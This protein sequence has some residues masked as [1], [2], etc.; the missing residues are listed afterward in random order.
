MTALQSAQQFIK[1][2]K[3]QADP[4]VRDGP[5][6]ID[7]AEQAWQ[8]ASF[9]LPNKAE[10]IAD[11]I[12]SKFFKERGN[13]LATNVLV[14][15][16]Y[17][18][19]LSKLLS[20]PSPN[21]QPSSPQ[22][23]L[24]LKSSLSRISIAP[25][26]NAFLNLWSQLD[27]SQSTQLMAQASYCISILYPLGTQKLTTEAF[28][29]SWGSF[30]K[31]AENF[32]DNASSIKIGLI[33]TRAYKNSL[34]N[35][36]SRKKVNNLF[37]QNESYFQAWLQRLQDKS[38][39][40]QYE[41]LRQAILTCGMDTL[42][43]L[44]T[45][46]QMTDSLE[47]SPICLALYKAFQNDRN[48][49]L[50][51]LPPLFDHYIA[52]L[53]K[54][55]GAII[56]ASSSSRVP[57]QTELNSASS[58]FFL[59]LRNLVDAQKRD[60]SAW[61]AVSQMVDVIGRENIYHPQ[62]GL[63]S[64]KHEVDIALNSLSEPGEDQESNPTPA[65]ARCLSAVIR[66][67]YDLVL[68]SMGALLSSFL[69]IP[70]PHPDH[71]TLL[72]LLLEYHTKTRTVDHYIETLIS[73]LS[74]DPSASPPSAQGRYAIS[75]SSPIL[76]PEHLGQLSKA[77]RQF[78]TSGQCNT[79]V[80]HFC[81]AL[82]ALH[83]HYKTA[84]RRSEADQGNGSRKSR[85][86]D[87]SAGH[88]EDLSN[89]ALTF[90]LMAKLGQTV[91]SSI[92]MTSLPQDQAEQ[93][94]SSLA[95]FQA[96][97]AQ[98][99]ISK[100]LKL[101]LQSEIASRGD[102]KTSLKRKR[103]GESPT[104]EA[105]IMLIGLLRLHY[106]LRMARSLA[107]PST[108]SPKLTK[109]LLELL[110]H[111][112]DE[113]LP[114]LYLEIFRTLFDLGLAMDATE[115]SQ[116]IDFALA[117]VDKT[118]MP[119]LDTIWS[120]FAHELTFGP[121]GRAQAGL[122]V[123]HMI[124]E[125]WLPVIEL[126]AS[127]QQLEAL[128]KVITRIPLGTGAVQD[129]QQLLSAGRL[130][131]RTLRS[132]QFWE[133]HNFRVALLSRLLN[134]TSN[135]EGEP[136]KSSH[137]NKALKLVVTYRLL[138]FFPAEYLRKSCRADLVETAIQADR[139][140]SQRVEGATET[141]ASLSTLRTFLKR[142]FGFLGSI[143]EQSTS[144]LAEFILHLLD[145]WTTA[146]Q[147]E[148]SQT[149]LD[150]FELY[151]TELLKKTVRADSGE[152]S[153]VL[154]T[155]RQYPIFDTLGSI[156][157]RSLVCL[158]DL[159]NKEFR[160]ASLSP[161]LQKLLNELHLHLLTDLHDKLRA[162]INASRSEHLSV[163]PDLLT[164]WHSLLVL[165]RWLG[166]EDLQ[167]S[168][169]PQ[170]VQKFTTTFAERLQG[171]SNDWTDRTVTMVV[172]ILLQELQYCDDMV[173]NDQLGLVVAAYVSQWKH[174][175]LA[176]KASLDQVVSN[177]CRQLSP[178]GFEYVLSLLDGAL[179]S[180]FDD[181]IDSSELVH[182]GSILL[183]D[184]PPNTLKIIQA[185]FTRCMAIYTD[186][187]KYTAI[188]T[189][190]RLQTL[191]FVAQHC[192]ERPAALRLLDIG[193]IWLLL[194]KCLSPS[195]RHEKVTSSSTF[196]QIISIASAIIRLRRDLTI[197]ML[198]HLGMILRQVTLCMR[199]CRPQLGSKQT[200]MVMSTQ[201]RWISANQPLGAEEAKALSR[202]L[203]TLTTKTIVR[204]HTASAETQKAESLA[205]PFSKH[206]AYVLKAYIEA[207]NDP[208]CVLA[209]D[210]RKELY[211]GLYALCSMIGE[212]SRD[213]LMVSGLDT[214]GKATMKAL[215]KEYEKQ[216]Y[217]GQ[218]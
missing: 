202:L 183:R 116:T 204:V 61:D 155:Y 26:I 128:A 167:R 114:E 172:A 96:G 20:S 126:T 162:A 82:K 40:A 10:V 191:E 1:A 47:E 7:L 136:E 187:E 107:L 161:D 198:P 36:S 13:V 194:S 153:K 97:F 56:S 175:S 205:A 209:L 42:F 110:S 50:K 163:V 24:W 186:N 17:W 98:N 121:E 44:D 143:E 133:F 27:A 210:V 192:A 18:G 45:I 148:L 87:S 199:Q 181:S 51:A 89:L 147:T 145:D 4:P 84:L 156:K 218:G 201:P 31:N 6:K 80:D 206:A 200:D 54:H 212:H 125:R 213:A 75:H 57:D 122:A 118:L 184:H 123:L 22:T 5:L 168:F 176:G 124:L 60:V 157:A 19:L 46:R 178:S 79:A 76:H 185:F 189:G 3:A 102:D 113:L 73:N 78:L 131:F 135:L 43:N 149:T 115:A 208:L 117:F 127:G 216:R 196:H 92:P 21:V 152:A 94:K 100:I 120:G 69:T 195:P 150:L 12:L 190:V 90:S 53:R 180:D 104:W 146:T 38:P 77:T 55:R 35:S 151:F 142:T 66:V 88:Q 166:L 160:F 188:S 130:L 34:S 177:A 217:S 68:P 158:I 164:Y 11:W 85:K 173:Q 39:A 197:P 14:N 132:A 37:V 48:V 165:G 41:Y 203:E 81:G 207:M 108:S 211:P 49:A 2:L 105:Q 129:G 70:V 170:L 74:P 52:S 86:S 103:R 71:F 159:L 99:S 8:D 62:T 109:K 179:S 106:T 59:C 182:L 144:D 193:S 119:R 95:E 91:F 16:R 23:S 29:E 67:D 215:W 9:H 138:L 72:E 93:L 137:Q 139:I 30:L 28:L 33:I 63:D 64:L 101:L 174:L 169:G 58:K 65:I 83:E 32:T 25:V 134:L 112:E 154:A 140:I 15:E 111:S 214:G 141:E 171:V